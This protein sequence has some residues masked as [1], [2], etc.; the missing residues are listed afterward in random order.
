[1]IDNNIAIV[2][3]GGWP[4]T[5]EERIEALSAN[6]DQITIFRA[7]DSRDFALTNTPTNV[8]IV[9]I[10]P[11]KTYLFPIYPIL[12]IFVFLY[13]HIYR[14]KNFQIIHSLD[15]FV[16]PFCGL[17]CSR[18]FKI[19]FVMSVR[20]LPE[21]LT[22]EYLQNSIRRFRIDKILFHFFLLAMYYLY[23]R[24]SSFVIFKSESEH[25]FFKSKY[26][27]QNDFS[28]EVI[29]TGVH[30]EGFDSRDAGSWDDILSDDVLSE[31]QFERLESNKVICYA[32][33]IWKYKGVDK[34]IDYHQHH[35]DNNDDYSLLIVGNP[36]DGCFHKRI[37]SLSTDQDWLV[38][39]DKRIPHSKMADL[40]KLSDVVVL[41]STDRHEGAPK[42]L[43]EALV[44]GTPCIASDIRGI[45]E[46]FQHIQGC[47]LINPEN[48]NDYK[49]ALDQ[50][51]YNNIRVGERSVRKD[52]D[53]QKN[54]QRIAKIY[55]KVN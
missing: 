45:K 15:Y 16:G 24:Y 4:D 36:I 44:C 14:G 8:T 54:Y 52:F 20:G 18:L 43:Q 1:M 42:L 41:L 33:R 50:C 46:P 32:G 10:A 5:F 39:H 38:L 47:I 12:F 27:L 48:P 11:R 23:C 40:L 26:G 49:E 34:L 22:I 30:L 53:L 29:P 19:S 25:S 9:D 6:V 37:K 35:I 17:L 3:F 7:H 31:S 28:S 55:K 13:E 51:L 2:S 21:Q